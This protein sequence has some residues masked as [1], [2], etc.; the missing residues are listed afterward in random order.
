MKIPWIILGFI[1]FNYAY[2]ENIAVQIDPKHI[3]HCQIAQDSAAI[4][5]GLMFRKHLAANQGM[6]FIFPKSSNWAFWMK[7]TLIPLDIIWLDANKTVLYISKNTPTCPQNT[8]NCPTYTPPS[9][10]KAK[11]VLEIAQG[12]SNHLNIYLQQHLQF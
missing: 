10:L 4:Q 12:Q 8:Q 1:I 7:N 9:H 3:I 11:Y 2:A 6:L 5:K